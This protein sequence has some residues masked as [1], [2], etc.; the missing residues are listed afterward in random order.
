MLNL[1]KKCSIF[2][3]FIHMDIDNFQSKDNFFEDETNFF[4][5]DEVLQYYKQIT[6]RVWWKILPNHE[7]ILSKVWNR[8]Q[9]TLVFDGSQAQ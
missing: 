3:S 7:D 5:S 8:I 6:D 1:L 4:E 9:G 2:P